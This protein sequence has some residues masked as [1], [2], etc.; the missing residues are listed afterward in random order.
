[1]ST[2]LSR[3]FSKISRVRFFFVLILLLG[4]SV[5]FT[6]FNTVVVFPTHEAA[7]MQTLEVSKSTQELSPFE[8]DG[9]SGN[10]SEVW[11]KTITNLPESLPNIQSAYGNIETIP[12]E[13][14]CIEHDRTYHTGEGGYIGR[15]QADNKL[16]LDII[17]YGIENTETIKKRTGL[18]TDAEAVFLYET[19]AETVYRAVRL[20]GAPCTDTTYAWGYGYGGGTCE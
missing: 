13:A 14:A 15:L 8:T 4:M 20:G 17:Q 12:F 10:L 3:F 7:L 11:N 16:R 1:M 19:I 18:S 5:Y 9:C 6:F 2:P